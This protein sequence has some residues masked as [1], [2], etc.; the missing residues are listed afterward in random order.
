MNVKPYYCEENVVENMF[1]VQLHSV[2]RVSVT[3]VW[4]TGL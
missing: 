4:E 1:N 2:G 3:L